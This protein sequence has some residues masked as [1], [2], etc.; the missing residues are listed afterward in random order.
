MPYVRC[1]R[2]GRRGYHPAPWSSM[3]RCSNCGADL[4]IPRHGFTESDVRKDVYSGPPPVERP[5]RR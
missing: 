2:C 4:E 5:D 3:A 1:P